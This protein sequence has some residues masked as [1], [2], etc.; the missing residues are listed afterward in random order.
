MTQMTPQQLNALDT[1][2]YQ[3]L[4]GIQAEAAAKALGEKVLITHIKIDGGL[5][6]ENQSPINVTEMVNDLGADGLFPATVKQDLDNPGE[7]IVQISISA[8]HHINNQGY[9]IWGLAAITDKGELYSYRRVEGDFKSYKPGDA[10]SFI[11]RLRFQTSN[12]EVI[13][14]TVDPSVVLVS[15]RDLNEFDEKHKAEEDPH[16]QYPLASIA[17]F[18]PY[19][20]NRVYSVGEICYS[21]D[22]ATGELSYWQWYSNVESLAGKSPLLDVNR[23]IGWADSTKPFYWIPY[24]GDQIGM[25]FFWLD[26]NAP[27]WAVM[28]INV[29]LPIAV[30]WR[31]ARRYPHLV[32]SNIINTGDIRGEFLRVLDQ[33]RGIDVERILNSGQ[34][35]AMEEHYH[36]YQAFRRVGNSEE[37]LTP[38]RNFTLT[39]NN[40]SGIR[41]AKS[42]NE[43]RPR[44]IARPMAITI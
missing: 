14:F 27:E 20:P 42:A 32:T 23:H 5:L 41:G 15:E 31:L 22:Q 19:D 33:G 3:T 34:L 35:D 37:L 16:G 39:G 2:G 30:Y 6:A 24:T 10:K 44:N 13:N 43:T 25:P 9:Q 17:Q 7:F 18:L 21:K 36:E 28:E 1:Q 11:Y 8:D 40:T 12:A 4:V 26:T 38:E 29:D